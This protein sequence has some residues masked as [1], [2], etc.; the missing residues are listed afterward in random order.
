MEHTDHDTETN[1]DAEELFAPANNNHRPSPRERRV[2]RYV[3]EGQTDLL[4]ALAGFDPDKVP[5]KLHAGALRV[6]WC[7]GNGLFGFEAIASATGLATKKLHRT[8]A[9]MRGA[10]KGRAA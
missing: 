1:L 6:A 10:E 9:A 5:R 2:P 4:L 8:L 3:T 7:H